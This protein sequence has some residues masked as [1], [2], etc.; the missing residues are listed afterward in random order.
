MEFLLINFYSL[1]SKTL[2]GVQLFRHITCFFFLRLFYIM[3]GDEGGKTAITGQFGENN[4]RLAA[5]WCPRYKV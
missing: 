5:E 2:S 3:I 1:P 4:E